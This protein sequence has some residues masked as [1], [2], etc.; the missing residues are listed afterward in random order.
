MT[1]QPN[2]SYAF[3]DDVF[4]SDSDLIGFWKPSEI[5][6]DPVLTLARKRR[7]LAYWVSDI[8]AVAGQPALRR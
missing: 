6:S 7:L 3:D 2:P 8:H 4:V 5:V 1:T